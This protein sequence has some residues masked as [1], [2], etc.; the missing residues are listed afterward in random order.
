M[1]HLFI[2][3]PSRGQQWSNFFPVDFSRMQT[4]LWQNASFVRIKAEKSFLLK[5][6][7]LLKT[8][9]LVS[10]IVLDQNKGLFSLMFDL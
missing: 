8:T 10:P 9:S 1:Y 2:R 3:I 6:W 5:D 7:L 4:V